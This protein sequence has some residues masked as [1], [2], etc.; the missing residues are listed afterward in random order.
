M[1]FP[2][3]K[4]RLMNVV[5]FHD[6]P[7]PWPDPSRLTLPSQK[8]AAIQLFAD[9]NPTVKKIMDMLLD[10]LDCWG[11]FDTYD[12]PAS[13]YHKGCICIVGDAAHAS[14]PHHGAGAGACI[15]DAAI[16]AELLLEAKNV[17]QRQACPDTATLLEKTF[18]AY[19]AVR[20]ERTQWLVASSRRTGDIF[21]WMDPECGRDPAKM[22]QE[23]LWRHNKIWWADIEAMVSEAKEHLRGAVE[24]L[25]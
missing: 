7:N 22:E 2:V 16:L 1:T 4:G 3:A 11:I 9:W 13:T 24:A 20:L 6:D 17:S 15:E 5:A 23:L 8:S 14:S 21:D 12:H 10:D 25:R 19:E 18:A